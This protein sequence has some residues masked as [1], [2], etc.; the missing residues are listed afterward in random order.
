MRADRRRLHFAAKV[1][2]KMRYL[3][4]LILAVALAAPVCQ[5]RA[6]A[7][8]DDC[9]VAAGGVAAKQEIQPVS[10]SRFP[11]ELRHSDSS[12]GTT[13]LK[14]PFTEHPLA[15]ARFRLARALLIT[16]KLPRN[17]LPF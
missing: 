4:T 15:I 6:V 17:G 11:P 10:L 5:P 12:P 16:T 14:R 3:R 9:G 7:A 8:G 2:T 1:G 13:S